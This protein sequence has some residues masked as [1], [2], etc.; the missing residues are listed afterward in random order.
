MLLIYGCERT[1]KSDPC[2]EIKDEEVGA[3]TRACRE[4]GAFLAADPLHG[5]DTATT[6]RVRDGETLIVDG[7]F[8][9]TR[10]QLGGYYM[11]DCRDLD[12]AL[13]LAALCPM[14]KEG[15]IEVRPVW[16]MAGPHRPVNVLREAL[17]E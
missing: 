17:A 9:E 16:E 4:R 2:G 5:T 12:E 10:E 15:S 6:V 1:P 13:E 7:P 11:L 8:A 3:F 14:A